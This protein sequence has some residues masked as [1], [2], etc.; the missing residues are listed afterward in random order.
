MLKTHRLMPFAAALAG[1]GFLSCMDAL[2]KSAASDAGAY[3]ATLLRAA[4]GTAIIA[5]IWLATPLWSKTK[6]RWPEKAVLVIHAERGVISAFMALSFFYALTKLPLAEA[7]AISF[8]APLIALYFARIFL[9][10]EIQRKAILASVL[11]LLGTVVIIG[12]QFGRTELSRDLLLGLGSLMFSALLYAYNF[13][14]IRRQSQ[15]ASP[16]EVASFHSGVSAL[17]LLLAAPFLWV[18]PQLAALN[19]IAMASVFTVA[20]AMAIAWAYAREEAQALV[21]TEYSG[22]LWASVLGWVF[23]RETVT[24]P[25]VF[26]TSLI[27]AGCWIAAR[28]SGANEEAERPAEQPG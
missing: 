14:V 19:T 5:P 13:T 24:L 8:M 16:V 6:W 28:Q 20:G 27:V 2:M 17:V 7:I 25:T 3:T 18:T 10:E 9:G 15:R 26:G 21:P 11:G 1:I 12:G 22:F 4:L 23:F